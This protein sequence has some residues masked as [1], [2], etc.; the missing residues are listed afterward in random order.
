LGNTSNDL[1]C[2]NLVHKAKLGGFDTCTINWRGLADCELS[3][4]KWHSIKSYTDFIEAIDYVI[5]HY[6]VSG[7]IFV[8]GASNGGN[9]LGNLLAQPNLPFKIDAA[10]CLACTP[11]IPMCGQ[12]IE[13]DFFGAIDWILG[14]L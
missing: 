9:T 5:K 11:N 8:I 1:Y 7:K 14:D 2:V 10:I 12:V 13:T 4:P 3:T 6:K